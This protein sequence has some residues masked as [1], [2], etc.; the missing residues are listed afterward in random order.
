MTIRSFV[1]HLLLARVVLNSKK[2][3][4]MRKI[5]LA[6]LVMALSSQSLAIGLKSTDKTLELTDILMQDFISKDFKGGIEKVKKHW[7]LPEVEMDNLL[8]LILQQWP[9]VDQRY[10]QAVGYEFLHSESI[11]DSFVRHYYLHKFNNHAIYWKFTFYKPNNKWVVNGVEF[12][13][14]LDLLYK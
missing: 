2:E 1:R 3:S 14:T 4:N 5:L 11:G 7:P 13:D 12:L 10:G 8:N 6:L 9:I